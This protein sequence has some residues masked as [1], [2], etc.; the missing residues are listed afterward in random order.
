MSNETPKNICPDPCLS[1]V[2]NDVVWIKE[3]IQE[4]HFEVKKGIQEVVDKVAITNGK[5]AE[6]SIWKERIMGIVYFLGATGFL[7][8]VGSQVISH[9]K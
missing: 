2:Q 9:F 3:R 7:Y 6:I 1:T 5:V 4:N 8:W